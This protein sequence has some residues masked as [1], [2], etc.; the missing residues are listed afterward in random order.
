MTVSLRGGR[1]RPKPRRSRLR[2]R[3]QSAA[4]PSVREVCL[5]GVAR[6][7]SGDDRLTWS[8]RVYRVEA[9]HPRPDRDCAGATAY[10]H[11]SPL[12]GDAPGS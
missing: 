12:A 7:W 9:T 5:I 2:A 4:G 10:V 1:S 3:P 11:L 6:D 8:G